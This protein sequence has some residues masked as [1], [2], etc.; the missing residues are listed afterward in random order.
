MGLDT[1]NSTGASGNNQYVHLTKNWNNTSGTGLIIFET[2]NSANNYYNNNGQNGS[3][4]NVSQRTSSEFTQ[5]HRQDNGGMC[6]VSGN[7]CGGVGVFSGGTS[8]KFML[9]QWVYNPSDGWVE[10]LNLIDDSGPN[11]SAYRA[12]GETVGYN[13]NAGVNLCVYRDIYQSQ[14][15]ARAFIGKHKP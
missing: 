8:Y 14:W 2:N 11:G 3:I 12:N 6:G 15:Y 7:W 10:V 9:D 13:S 1:V 5:T 4:F